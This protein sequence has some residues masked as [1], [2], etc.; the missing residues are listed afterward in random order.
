MKRLRILYHRLRIPFPSPRLRRDNPSCDIAA[1][2]D[3]GIL[4]GF[5]ILPHAVRKVKKNEA[6]GAALISWPT[7]PPCSSTS[8]RTIGK[9]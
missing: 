5:K 3:G 6:P 1:D 8:R 9:P 4:D 2:P 7:R